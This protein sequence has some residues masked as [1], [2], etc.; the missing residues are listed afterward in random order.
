MELLRRGFGMR[1]AVAR[2]C[3]LREGL[4][5]R[6]FGRSSRDEKDE[7][8]IRAP[9]RLQRDRGAASSLAQIRGAIRW[10]FGGD[11]SPQHGGGAVSSFRRNRK[12]MHDEDK[13][14]VEVGAAMGLASFLAA[15]F[16]VMYIPPPA[17]PDSSSKS[18]WPAL[19][20]DTFQTDRGQ[21]GQEQLRQRQLT[22]GR[23]AA[24]FV[25][26]FFAFRSARRFWMKRWGDLEWQRVCDVYP[27][28]PTMQLGCRVPVLATLQTAVVVTLY[29]QGR[30]GID[31]ILAIRH[32]ADPFW[33]LLDIRGACDGLLCVPTLL[34]G[35]SRG[36]L[37]GSAHE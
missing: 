11:F 35:E 8:A 9:G 31:R 28:Q 4:Q 15:V 22:W 14:S 34:G 33:A 12:G 29:T 26:G 16:Y 23:L 37:V 6:G 27:L 5:K 13:I 19:H 1:V 32:P 24:P 25:F 20:E 3:G 18:F 21:K 7:E 2:R 36:S 10:V 30:A 17:D